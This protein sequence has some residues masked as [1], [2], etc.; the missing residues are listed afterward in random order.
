MA[1]L[2]ISD[3]IDDMFDSLYLHLV[4]SFYAYATCPIYG[5]RLYSFYIEGTVVDI[6][7]SRVSGKDKRMESKSRQQFLKD[8]RQK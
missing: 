1:C 2:T 3:F 8:G 5:L 4:C 7:R 6:V